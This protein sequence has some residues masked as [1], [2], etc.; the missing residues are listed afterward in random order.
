MG[1]RK[2]DGSFLAAVLEQWR[3]IDKPTMGGASALLRL[4]AK[5]D[6]VRGEIRSDGGGVSLVG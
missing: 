3:D 1:Q 5:I 4:A 6:L 2:A